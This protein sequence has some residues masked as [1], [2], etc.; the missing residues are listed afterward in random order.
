MNYQTPLGRARGLGSAREGSKFWWRQRLSAVALLPLTLWLAISVGLLPHASRAEVMAWL[1]AP[2]NTLL[3]LA[4]I[5]ITLY[6]AMLGLQ[7]VIEDYVHQPWPKLFSL[8]IIRLVMAF[9]ALV[10]SL[11]ILHS[12]FV[13]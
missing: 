1:S 2:W 12:V 4:F 8:L 6:H 10:S 7:V 3:L 11:A 9:L 5:L 13:G